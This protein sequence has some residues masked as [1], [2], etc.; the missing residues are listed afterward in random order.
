MAVYV[1]KAIH[2]YGRMTMCHMMA[3]ST[4]E[5]LSMADC[6]GVSR[7][8]LQNAGQPTEHMDVCK[9]KRAEAVSLGAVEVTGRVLAELI[10]LRR[11]TAKQS[12]NTRP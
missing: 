3:D 8:W 5:L 12:S 9:S 2:K 7:R 10:R 4:E 1:D 6:I 11:D